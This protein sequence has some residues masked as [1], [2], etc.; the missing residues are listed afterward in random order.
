MVDFVS[1][2]SYGID[3]LINL[4]RILRSPVGCPWDREQTHESIRRNMLEEAFEVIEAIDE[5]N[6]NLLIEELG[7]VL[8]QVLFHSDI[9]ES[10]ERFNFNDVADATCK[11]LIRRHPHVFGDVHVKD[12]RESLLVWDDIKRQ[13]KK[14]ETVTDAMNSVAK[15]LPALWR[16][17]KIQ[18]KAAKI[19][20]DWPDYTGAMS[21]LSSEINELENAIASET[22]V[23]AEKESCIEEELGDILFSIVNVAR[24]FKID[25]EHALTSA[26]DKFVTRFN[27]IEQMAKENGRELTDMSLDEMEELY[28]LSKLER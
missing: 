20:F 7:D 23:T 11:K 3:D 26:I 9:A 15:S 13:E 10:S 19:G 17:E 18:G 24:F 1:K 21:S 12:G 6:D 8:M 22:S 4:M 16:A 27:F 28:Q 5:K 2:S 14:H 25:P